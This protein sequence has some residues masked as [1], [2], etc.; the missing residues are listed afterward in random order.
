MR[1]KAL[2][3]MMICLSAV[4]LMLMSV[5][6]IPVATGT[7]SAAAEPTLNKTSRNI[8][9]G[10]TYNLNVNNKIAGA[11]Y[12]WSTSDK[13][14]ATVNN[15]G[16]VTGK[17]KGTATIT[18]TI[19]TKD[20]KIYTLDCKVTV[21][22]PATYFRINNKVTVLNLGQTYDFNRSIPK[23]SND[24]TTWSTSDAT[25]ANPDKLGVVTALKEG[26]VTITGKT[27][28]GK[29]DSVTFKVIDKDGI[30]TN[31]KELDALL[32]TGVGKITIKTED[33]LTFK[34]PRSSNDKTV[35]VI[36]APNA[37]VI[38]YG[39]FKYVEINKIAAN[40]YY[41]NSDG[42]RIVVNGTQA[43]IAV[44][45]T[46][47]VK[48]EV[49]SEGTK[50]TIENNGVIEEVLLAKG[51]ELEITGTSDEPVPVVINDA[52]CKITS[53][54]PLDVTAKAKAEITL[55]KGAEGTKIQ[56]ETK[57]AIP[58]IKGDV[59]VEVKVGD[60]DETVPVKGDPIPT[61][62]IGG[63]GGSY[64]PV[65]SITFNAVLSDIS[66][67]SII[68]ANNNTFTMDGLMLTLIKSV[69]NSG[70]FVDTWKAIT[71]QSFVDNGTTVSITGS[72]GSLAKTVSVTG[73]RYDGKSFTVTSDSTGF[74]LTIAGE[75][76][77]SVAIRRS[78]DGKQITLS[79][80]SIAGT[81]DRP[82]ATD[83]VNT[84]KTVKITYKG[85]DYTI[86][87]PSVI[88]LRTLLNTADLAD[89]WKTIENGTVVP[90]G[91]QQVTVL[92]GK[93]NATRNVSYGG[94]TYTA[95]VTES[96]ISIK[97]GNVTVT[98]TPSSGNINVSVN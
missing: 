47:K 30:V 71:S 32:E 41:D 20:K 84:L 51:T 45:S 56:A 40:T 2:K 14:I 94:K 86:G 83:L 58:T 68:S 10:K 34:I 73:G 28:S 11:K 70:N 85:T 57:D 7:V 15:R 78:S 33:K 54:V 31:Q 50:V 60:G 48:I 6:V 4:A 16:I 62:P 17:K 37:E 64:P 81:L 39:T 36:D 29:T 67:I 61:G 69:I 9:V 22:E 43:R 75:S 27:L 3:L 8:L 65:S 91:G 95:T 25:I 26:T 53:S 88:G 96:Y 1:T 87:I 66:S 98:F 44:G 72:A 79:A 13:K 5:I 46:S 55:L 52:S 82:T 97:D 92:S 77:Y 19:T 18:C 93:G 90:V 49:T 80:G 38:N 12:A 74:D 42:N 35:L 24:K 21:I 89:N 76:G 23:T 63:G 59:T